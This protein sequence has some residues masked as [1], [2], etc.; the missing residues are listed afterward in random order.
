LT[1]SKYSIYFNSEIVMK[2]IFLI[3]N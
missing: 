1:F 2:F 3:P